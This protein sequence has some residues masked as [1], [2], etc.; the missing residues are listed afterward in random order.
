MIS[1]SERQFQRDELNT[2][3]SWLGLFADD[4][5]ADYASQDGAG[6]ARGTN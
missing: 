6:G 3:I 2:E 1:Q 4:D 5:L